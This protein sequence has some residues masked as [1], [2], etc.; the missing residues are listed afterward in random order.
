[1][2]TITEEST[3]IKSQK[4]SFGPKMIG[5]KYG[6]GA[7]I[8]AHVRYDDNCGNGHNSFSITAKVVTPQ[9]ERRGDIQVGGCLHE[10][11]A[12][13]FPELAPFIKWHLCS[14]DGPM[15]YIANTLYLAGDTDHRGLHR[16]E[17]RQLRNGKTKQPVWERVMRNAAGEV[18]KVGERRDSDEKPLEVLSASWEP[19]WI[20][21]EGKERQLDAARHSAVWPDATDEDLT[22]PGLKERLET[23]L[24]ALLAEFRK[25]IEAL[26][27]VW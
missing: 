20:T 17:K 3:L 9:S 10:D 18:V 22:T 14:S 23:R 15:H 6:P 4:R 2:T 1:M 27:F 19:V 21:G 7:M 5:S 24:P 26:G 13:K 16:G 25:D 11:V 8:T 12:E